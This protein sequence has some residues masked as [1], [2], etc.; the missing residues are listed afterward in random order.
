ML[1]KT[2]SIKQAEKSSKILVNDVKTT[3][4]DESRPNLYK[5]LL[6][7]PIEILFYD[8]SFNWS[9]KTIVDVDIS[10]ALMQII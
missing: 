6:S 4:K 1:D 10:V 5:K 8:L 2:H 9:T 7:F 3:I